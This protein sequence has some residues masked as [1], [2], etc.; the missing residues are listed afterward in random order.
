M[1]KRFF[2]WL[3]P[4]SPSVVRPDTSGPLQVALR[5]YVGRLSALEGELT[6]VKVSMDAVAE[7]L[8]RAVAKWNKR[9]R[10]DAK[11]LVEDQPESD[12]PRILALL[13]SR[14]RA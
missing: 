14:R 11:Q 10:D 7:G 2:R 3:W 1:I 9:A 6:G 5:D 12:D 8:H 4:E 13:E